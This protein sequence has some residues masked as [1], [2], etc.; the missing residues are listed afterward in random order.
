MLPSRVRLG[1]QRNGTASQT[2]ALPAEYRSKQTT[3]QINIASSAIQIRNTDGQSPLYYRLHIT[4][5]RANLFSSAFAIFIG[6]R[7]PGTTRLPR[8]VRNDVSFSF[9]FLEAAI[10][11]FRY[12]GTRYV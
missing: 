12:V 1:H 5:A 11:R 4:F 9:D 2:L 6:R 3:E 8:N 10:S 7:V